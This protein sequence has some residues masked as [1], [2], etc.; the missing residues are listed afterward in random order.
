LSI[1]LGIVLGPELSARQGVM[2][3]PGLDTSGAE[4]SRHSIAEGTNT[5]MP[6]S[7]LK[8]GREKEEKNVWLQS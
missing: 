4:A 7:L 8:P 3:E 6:D 1:S 2:K 5:E